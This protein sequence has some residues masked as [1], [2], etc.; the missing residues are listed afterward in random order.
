MCNAWSGVVLPT[1]KVLWEMGMN[2]HENIIEKHKLKDD[3]IGRFVRVEITPRN[4]DYL[5]PDE[6]VFQIDEKETPDWFKASHEKACWVAWEKWKGQLD[7]ILV[8]KKIIHPFEDVKPRKI[9]SK[10][11]RL[12]QEWDSVQDSVYGSV[13][14]SLSFSIGGSVRDSVRD[15]VGDCSIWS[16]VWGSVRDSVGDSVGDFRD[17]LWVAVEAYFGSF[18]VL[19]QWKYVEHEKGVYPFQSVVDLWE[20]GLVPFF[21]GKIWR[22]SGGKNAKVLFEISK[23]E[24]VSFS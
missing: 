12:L 23:E 20:Q 5:S 9:L 7:K 16:S 14:I 1:R 11:I 10:H 24:L 17:S 8:K 3:R 21:D 19:P 4:K 18:F 2:S 13:W 6:W 22:L 15:S